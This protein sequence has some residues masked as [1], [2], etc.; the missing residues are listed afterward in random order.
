MDILSCA[1]KAD[2][3]LCEYV[4]GLIFA[5]RGTGAAPMEDGIENELNNCDSYRGLSS[6]NEHFLHSDHLLAAASATFICNLETSVG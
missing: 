2:V 4:R 1:I 5:T 3:G 6:L